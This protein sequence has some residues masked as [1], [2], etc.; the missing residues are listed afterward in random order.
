M[1]TC[2]GGRWEA[3]QTF[4]GRSRGR[5]TRSRVA[6]RPNRFSSKGWFENFKTCFSWQK[7]LFTGTMRP[8]V[9]TPGRQDS[10]QVLEPSGSTDMQAWVRLFPTRDTSLFS[11]RIKSHRKR[12][13][14]TRQ[15]N[16]QR[17]PLEDLMEKGKG[18]PERWLRT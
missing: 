2:S 1:K 15:R 14:E 13:S 12:Q 6:V 10:S 17:G 7:A 11:G 3:A 5:G 16:G 9:L 18:R 8:A 4:P